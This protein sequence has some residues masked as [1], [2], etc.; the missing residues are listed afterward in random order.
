MAMDSSYAMRNARYDLLNAE[1]EVKEVLAIGLPQVN[2]TA[3]Y[4]Q[5]LELPVS[6][7]PNEFFGG[8]PGTFT[9]VQFGL[10]YNLTGSITASQLIFDGTYIVGLRAS[11]TYV[12]LS[13]NA[14]SKTA[15]EVKS[16]VAQAYYGALLA[17]ENL[18][19]LKENL[20]SV[21]KL[22][23]ETEALYANGLVEEQDA[24]QLRLNSNQLKTAIANTERYLALARYNLNFAIGIP[25]QRE[26]V[27]TDGVET[28]VALSTNP[29]YLQQKG[30]LTT[31]PDFLLAGTTLIAQNQ[32][33]RAEQAAYLPSLSAFLTHQQNAQRN[34]LNFAESG[35]PW[36]P[37]TILGLNLNIPIFSGFQRN[38]RVERARIEVDRAET[39]LYQT[40]EALQLQVN[41][42]MA[43]YEN[44]LKNWEVQKESKALAEKIYRRTEVK[45]SEGVASSF[46]LNVSEN[47]K[48]IEQNKY[49]DATMKLLTAK[50]D[51]DRAL[52]IY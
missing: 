50:E 39:N 48:I 46:E 36:F 26:V 49:I 47:Q 24:D 43:D 21:D 37:A 28:L 17:Q 2:A 8:E 19:I 40:A 4:Q 31:H 15:L 7:I 16:I 13:R 14:Q 18:R 35:Q 3:Q 52:N 27:L 45:Y 29:A 22:L 44:A 25:L 34:R 51:L 23:R 30:N 10:E 38:H 42:T 1:K 20:A 5:F 33:L 41:K 6:L 11:R 9:K 12:E 32:K